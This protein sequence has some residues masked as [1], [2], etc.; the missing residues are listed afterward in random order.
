MSRVYSDSEIIEL[1]VELLPDKDRENIRELAQELIFEI[2]GGG[3]WS[4]RRVQFGPRMAYRLL[5]A[6]GKLLNEEE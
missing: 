3:R 1:S 2:H 6:V 4:Q 5:Y